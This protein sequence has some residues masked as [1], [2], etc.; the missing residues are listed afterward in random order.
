ME[1]DSG[2]MMRVVVVMMMMSTLTPLLWLTKKRR[3]L[4]DP[5]HLQLENE[6]FARTA[7]YEGLPDLYTAASNASQ[8]VRLQ[9]FDDKRS[10]PLRCHRMKS[11]THVAAHMTRRPNLLPDLE[12]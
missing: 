8:S 4:I 11:P 10:I 5:F 6:S 2:I 12:L 7:A 1:L 3:H 9:E